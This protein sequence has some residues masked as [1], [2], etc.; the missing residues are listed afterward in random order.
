MN[1]LPGGLSDT[2]VANAFLASDEYFQ[3]HRDLTGLNADMLGRSP[4]AADTA[5]VT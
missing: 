2:A 1:A 4:D 3:A 5:T